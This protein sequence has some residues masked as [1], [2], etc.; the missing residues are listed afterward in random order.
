MHQLIKREFDLAKGNE[1]WD[2]YARTHDLLGKERMAVGID[3]DTRE[4]FVGESATEI[5]ASLKQDG[6]FRPLF[7]RRV[8]GPYYTH[9]GGRR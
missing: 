2:E 7:F 8:G 1:V 5:V 3:P 9:R 6:R 4:V